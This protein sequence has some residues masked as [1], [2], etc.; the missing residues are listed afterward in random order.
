MPWDA[1][2]VIEGNNIHH[3]MT[4]LGDGGMIYTLGPQGNRPFLRPNGAGRSYPAQPKPPLR[5]KPMSQIVRNYLHDN[6]PSS[7]FQG[8][9][10]G[11]VGSVGDIRWY[12]C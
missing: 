10:L 9:L 1:D 2:N 11:G 4:R 6:G 7:I 8:G 5:I 3:V 12:I